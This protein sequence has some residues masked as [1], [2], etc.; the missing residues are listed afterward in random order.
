[1]WL[2]LSC[3]CP[4]D[5]RHYYSL[6]RLPISWRISLCDDETRADAAGGEP[7]RPTLEVS[8]SGSPIWRSVQFAFRNR[9][10]PLTNASGLLL[11]RYSLP[12]FTGRCTS[13][14]VRL[15]SATLSVTSAPT[16]SRSSSIPLS[17]TPPFG[18][19]N[20]VF[21]LTS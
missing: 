7:K 14:R 13:W 9:T 18:P 5:P 11:R 8:H 12:F 6:L 19:M 15:L 4:A 1:R 21:L 10:K 2:A 3:P 20:F 17:L 16:C